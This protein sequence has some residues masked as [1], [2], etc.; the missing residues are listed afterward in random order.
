MA[1]GRYRVTARFDD[2]EQERT[3]EL[4]GDETQQLDFDTTPPASSQK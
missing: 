3:V 4:T 1:P 2:D